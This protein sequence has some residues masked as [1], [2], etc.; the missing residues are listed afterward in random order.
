MEGGRRNQI[1]PDGTASEAVNWGSVVKWFHSR[2]WALQIS[3]SHFKPSMKKDQ[4]DLS[5]ARST[6]SVG[7][8]PISRFDYWTAGEVMARIKYN[9]FFLIS[10]QT[11]CDS[12]PQ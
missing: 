8:G 3:A 6:R 9:T 11:K 2:I 10:N 4:Q 5:N 12:S 1:A 7:S